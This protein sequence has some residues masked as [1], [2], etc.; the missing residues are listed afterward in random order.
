M[1]P[2]AL[3]PRYHWYW[4]DP[5]DRAIGDR[6][7][8]GMRILD[9]GSGR[10]PS[11]PVEARP[12][13]CVYTGLDLSPVELEAAGEDAYDEVIVGDITESIPALANRFDLAVSW[14]VL[15]HVSRLDD[16]VDHIQGYL[17]VG[18]TL[19]C[20]LSGKFSVY[21]LAN[22]MLPDR[23]GHALVTKIM[24]RTPEESPVFAARYHRCYATGLRG[25]FRDW[26]DLEI[27]PFYRAGTYFF[28]SPKLL[29]VFLAYENLAYR[30]RM[31]NLASHYLVVATR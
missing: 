23:V 16:A 7:R 19:V 10:S 2:S 5:F 20:F 17:R 25:A 6:L 29:K 28:F 8:P 11:V 1:D 31:A 18:G 14:Q 26:S 9:I 3:P 13:D 15:E 22:R 21:A 24:R 4:R 30:R 12:A 27:T